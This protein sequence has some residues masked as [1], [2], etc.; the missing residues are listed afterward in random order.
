MSEISSTNNS[1]VTK[2]EVVN[3]EKVP[4]EE[5]FRKVY[6]SSSESKS[7]FSNCI[8]KLDNFDKKISLP[9]Q[10][11]TPNIF[12]EILFFIGAKIFNTITVILYLVFLLIFCILVQKN[13]KAFLIYLCHVITG[14]LITLFTKILIGRERPTLS[15][16]RHFHKVRKRETSNSMPS[17]DSLQAANFAMIMILYFNGNIK[18][19]SLA[20]IPYSM[21]GR[22]FYNCHYWFDCIIGAFL[23]IFIS[24]GT[25]YF[26]IYKFNINKYDL[27]I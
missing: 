16:K 15:V 9:L 1:E 2:L 18:Y 7:Y 10:S 24:L 25:Y 14:G 17:G 27:N 19:L 21:I 3:P 6:I 4:I 8:S 20:V 5:N 11:Y 26:I 13:I 23:G 22:V 12:I